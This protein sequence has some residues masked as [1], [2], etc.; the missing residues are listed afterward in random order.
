LRGVNILNFDEASFLAGIMSCK[1]MEV[2][3]QAKDCV[4]HSIICALNVMKYY[5]AVTKFFSQA[6]EMY[7]SHFETQSKMK[8]ESGSVPND[9]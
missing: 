3:S 1:D 4:Y 9:G 7:F 5:K 2:Y 8:D 6:I